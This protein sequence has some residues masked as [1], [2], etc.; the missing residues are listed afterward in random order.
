VGPLRNEEGL[1][2]GLSALKKIQEEEKSVYT[3][4][5]SRIMNFEWMEAL[6]IGN[7]LDVAMMT[8]EGALFRKESRE[9]HY[10]ED[11]SEHF[12]AGDNQN[13][14]VETVMKRSDDQIRIS[15][16]PMAYDEIKPG[17]FEVQ[18]VDVPYQTFK[19]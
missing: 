11:F 4:G 17:E 6:E 13:W 9:S 19:A 8:T 18:K 12:P 10:R 3:K 15:K 16:V 5:K 7:M 14:G 2:K 1:N